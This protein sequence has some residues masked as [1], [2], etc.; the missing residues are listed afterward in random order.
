MSLVIYFRENIQPVTQF[1]VVEIYLKL[2]NSFLCFE[3]IFC[4]YFQTK[5]SQE[6]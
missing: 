5:T 4:V 3:E 1:D 6:R 2:L